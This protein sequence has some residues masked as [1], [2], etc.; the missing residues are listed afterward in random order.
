MSFLKRHWWWVLVLGSTAV[1]MGLGVGL[2]FWWH[3]EASRDQMVLDK[4]LNALR[5]VKQF[6]NPKAAEK[7]AEAAEYRE[8]Q[9]LD[10]QKY[11][12][13]PE[14]VWDVLV[15]GVFPNYTARSQLFEFR[16]RYLTKLQSFLPRMNAGDPEQLSGGVVGVALFAKAPTTANAG[17]FYWGEWISP[18]SAPPESRETNQV[19]L[20]ESQD[21][22]WLQEDIVDAIRRTNDL[23]F[24]SREIPPGERTVAN[25][26]VKELREIIIGRAAD[27]VSSARPFATSYAGDSPRYRYVTAGPGAGV[28]A[29]LGRLLPEAPGVRAPVPSGLASNNNGGRFLV[30][31]F[32]LTVTADGGNYL[33]LVRQLG[34]TR[35]YITVESVDFTM[36]PETEAGAKTLYLTQAGQRTLYGPRALATV[37]IRGAS[38][39]F[40]LAERNDKGELERGRSTLPPQ[41]A[42]SAATG[43]NR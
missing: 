31:P 10:I 11:V 40:E 18:A 37:V 28:G 32:K 9:L 16:T 12:A 33:E 43:T 34:G 7:A 42:Q 17:S 21:D 19:N 29:G 38:L 25:S 23:W 3:A 8:K 2:F 14:S 30:L 22:I 6:Y 24:G 39:I 26:V 5:G 15:P 27:D 35:S 20:R 4:S 1:L 36:L 41:S 13:Q